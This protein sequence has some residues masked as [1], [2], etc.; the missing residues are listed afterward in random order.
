VPSVTSL[1]T[2]ISTKNKELREDSL[3]RQDVEDV[4]EGIREVNEHF[5]IQF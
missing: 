2:A 5:A 1:A 4:Y 3:V